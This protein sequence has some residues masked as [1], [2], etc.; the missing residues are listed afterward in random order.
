[1]AI[2]RHDKVVKI[3]LEEILP[4]IIIII[5]V[6]IVIITITI[7]IFQSIYNYIPKTN[8][9]LGYIVL[10]PCCSYNSWYT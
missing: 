8:H 5:V 6:I 4:L 10:Q 7:I 3:Q 9:A 2:D 1:M